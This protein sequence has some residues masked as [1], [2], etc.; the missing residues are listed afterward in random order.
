MTAEDSVLFDEG[1]TMSAVLKHVIICT[2]HP[3]IKGTADRSF[4]DG[5]ILSVAVHTSIILSFL[6]RMICF[7]QLPG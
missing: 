7:E 2:R 4:Y 3:I 1:G 6:V 5:M